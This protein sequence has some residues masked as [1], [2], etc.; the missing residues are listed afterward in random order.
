MAKTANPVLSDL[1]LSWKTTEFEA[2]DG[3]GPLSSLHQAGDAFVAVAR[4]DDDG[5]TIEGSGVMVGPGLLLTATHVLDEFPKRG[6]GPL[7][8]TF[9]PNGARAWL[10]KDLEAVRKVGTVSVERILSG[11]V[12]YR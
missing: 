6:S 8:I 3:I 10:P 7:F 2:V 11:Y 12:S 5:L 1:K 9:L 4:L